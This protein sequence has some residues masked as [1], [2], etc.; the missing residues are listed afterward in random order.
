MALFG[1][2]V[3]SATFATFGSDECRADLLLCVPITALVTV[4]LLGFFGLNVF[5]GWQVGH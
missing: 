3:S 5:C 2:V 1:K 4:Q